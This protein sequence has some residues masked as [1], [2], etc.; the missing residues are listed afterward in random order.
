MRMLPLGVALVLVL[1]L[2]GC[3]AENV[4]KMPDVT[5]QRLDVALSDIEKVGFEDDVEV[6]GG[7]LFGV[8]DESNWEV[9]AQSPAA[10]A[11]VDGPR[12][13]VDRS[14]DDDNSDEAAE[15][16][17]PEETE[18]KKS[19][20]DADSYVYAGPAYEVVV[21]D[22]NV[23][24]ANL[25]QHW[26]YTEK[27]DV[28]VAT[29]KDPIKLIISDLVR[30]EGTDK[31]IVQVVTD[32]EIIEAES[33]ATM[34]RFMEEHGNE[35]FRDVI[36]PKE[37]TDWVAYY[38]GGFDYDAGKPDDEAFAIDWWVASDNPESEQ[39]RPQLAG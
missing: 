18:P 10:G 6:L 1:G 26:V 19:E 29:Y 2:A 9:C 15:E 14:C 16:T 21:V 7:G 3:G 39:W 24:A 33:N 5:G 12:L 23:S 30:K 38:T 28:S 8:I 20:S 36:A 31:L 35:Y 4:M 11:P 32:K 27:F 37:K 13:T 25:K 17:Q 22:E 34:G